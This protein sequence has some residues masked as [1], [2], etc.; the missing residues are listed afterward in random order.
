[1]K[2]KRKHKITSISLCY[3]IPLDHPRHQPVISARQWEN[4]YFLLD[5][6]APRHKTFHRVQSCSCP[7]PLL[8][9]PLTGTMR[10]YLQPSSPTCSFSGTKKSPALSWLANCQGQWQAKVLHSSHKEFQATFKQ[11][12]VSQVLS[13]TRKQFSG[14]ELYLLLSSPPQGYFFLFDSK[15]PH[16]WEAEKR[17]QANRAVLK[18]WDYSYQYTINV[19][20]QETI[21]S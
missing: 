14:A 13:H 11:Q 8:C 9:P 3:E 2:L 4:G 20:S 17:I 15:I 7:S 10:G 1:M 19:R 12:R 6:G 5:Q 18:Q 16:Q 21:N